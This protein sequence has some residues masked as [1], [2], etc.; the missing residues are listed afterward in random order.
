MLPIL[1]RVP[2]QF[3][4][5]VALLLAKK[6]AI[7]HKDSEEKG[8]SATLIADAK[9]YVERLQ[10]FLRAYEQRRH[11][12]KAPRRG[13]PRTSLK[14][15]TPQ[16][17]GR[18]TQSPARSPVIVPSTTQSWSSKCIS[19]L[20]PLRFRLA[21]LALLLI[22]PVLLLILSLVF[23]I[24]RMLLSNRYASDQT[25][26]DHTALLY[27]AHASLPL[28][29]AHLIPTMTFPHLFSVTYKTSALTAK[30]VRWK[31]FTCPM[32]NEQSFQLLPPLELLKK[33]L[34]QLNWMVRWEID[35][36]LRLFTE[37]LDYVLQKPL[38]ELDKAI[39]DTRNRSHG[40]EIL[41]SAH[42]LFPLLD[43][44]KRP[45]YSHGINSYGLRALERYSVSLNEKLGALL[46]LLWEAVSL[47]LAV[48]DHYNN[49]FTV[50]DDIGLSHCR[51]DLEEDL[52]E[53]LTWPWLV[54]ESAER[55]Y[56]DVDLE[57]N[58][59]SVFNNPPFRE[60]TGSR[61]RRLLQFN[62]TENDIIDGLATGLHDRGIF[63]DPTDIWAWNRSSTA[64]DTF[65]SLPSRM[66]CPPGLKFPI[67]SPWSYLCSSPSLASPP[68][69][70]LYPFARANTTTHNKLLALQHLRDVLA[71]IADRQKTLHQ[72]FHNYSGSIAANNH[73]NEELSENIRRDQ[74]E[75]RPTPKWR[76]W[77]RDPDS[78][79][80]LWMRTRASYQ[81]HKSSQRREDQVSVP[82]NASFPRPPRGLYQ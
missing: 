36:R 16:T 19:R 45:L 5:E 11:R 80:L 54:K 21:L 44:W 71:V 77:R 15:P 81:A 33:W 1:R 23:R 24:T 58:S 20:V 17:Q 79:E 66:P 56:G 2:E 52:S 31:Y 4:D 48:H 53:A 65:Q 63:I 47:L 67:G 70:H 40:Q 50:L 26:L 18:S 78:Y 72:A 7:R 27:V 6:E 35:D 75:R 42:E 69:G 32:T 76:F 46:P 57:P 55:D 82:R 13:R 60:P 62:K 8:E 14:A 61:R 12:T 9:S 73:A 29:F 51:K 59:T 30:A 49:V 28:L 34:Q 74:S 3:W 41:I 25:L 38:K 37:L 10:A 64:N 68:S 22:L 43:G 39:L